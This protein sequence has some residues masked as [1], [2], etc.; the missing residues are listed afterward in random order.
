M[1][2]C[3]SPGRP[4]LVSLP[5]GGRR[6]VVTEAGVKERTRKGA[7]NSPEQAGAPARMPGP[8]WR[9]ALAP[10]A[11]AAPVIAVAVRAVVVTRGSP[12]PQAA[13]A[14]PSASPAPGPSPTP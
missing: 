3:A 7:A 14:P 13:G 1:D 6:T 12:A 10:L 8:R 11:A 9:R 4:A 5:C 2:G